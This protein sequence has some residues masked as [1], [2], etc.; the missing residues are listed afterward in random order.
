M[1]AIIISHTGATD[2]CYWSC[3]KN[4]YFVK[5]FLPV[6]SEVQLTSVS[7]SLFHCEEA[8]TQNNDDCARLTTRCC[9]SLTTA[10]LVTDKALV[11]PTSSAAQFVRL[12][13][14]L[15][16]STK[17]AYTFQFSCVRAPSSFRRSLYAMSCNPNIYF[18]YRRCTFSIRS[19]SFRSL[20]H[21][22]GDAYKIVGIT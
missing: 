3:S 13:N 7:G 12:S 19:T 5:C 8:R 18:V 15:Y 21:R 11:T 6:D 17:S 4:R 2:K 1:Y 9:C 10:A 22:A 16:I 14:I 20:G